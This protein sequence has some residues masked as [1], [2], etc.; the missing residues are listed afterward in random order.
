MKL[1]SRGVELIKS[2]EELHLTSYDDGTGTWT[3]G[4]GHTRSVH[5]G[6]TITLDTAKRYF[7]SDTAAAIRAVNE[8]NIPLTQSQFDA[9]VALN[10]NCGS[11][12]ISGRSTIGKALRLGDWRSAW[13]G[14]TL[15]SATPGMELGQARRRTAEMALFL[16]DGRHP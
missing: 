13:K 5:P 3:I 7:D 9:L 10:F 16:A 2:F 4:W 15:W 14:F 1:G 6:T 11:G 8:L 12:T